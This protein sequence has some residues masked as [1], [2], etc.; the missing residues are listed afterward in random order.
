MGLENFKKLKE[1]LSGLQSHANENLSETQIQKI[2]EANDVLQQL[3]QESNKKKI[4]W[5]TVLTLGM[6]AASL[7]VEMLKSG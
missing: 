1:V 7:L 6:Q 2:E 5:E 4:N 3:E